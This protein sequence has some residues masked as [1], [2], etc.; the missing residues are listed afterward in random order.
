MGKDCIPISLL[1]G[2]SGDGA[3]CKHAFEVD[4]GKYQGSHTG[5]VQQSYP[6]LN[7]KP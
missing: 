7:P 1:Q 2:P 3:N 4:L 6:I 5:Q